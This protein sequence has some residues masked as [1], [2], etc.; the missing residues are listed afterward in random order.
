MSRTR[1]VCDQFG[2]GKNFQFGPWAEEDDLFDCESYPKIANR[3]RGLVC[4]TALIVF[5]F[6]ELC[7]YFCWMGGYFKVRFD[8]L[9]S[10]M[11]FYIGRKIMDP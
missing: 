8:V 4:R 5:S 10:N 9:R 7:L 1:K 11:G 2:E 6:F 3:P